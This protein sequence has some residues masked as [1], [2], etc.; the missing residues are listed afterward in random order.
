MDR[1]KKKMKFQAW[2]GL[3][4]GLCF[5]CLFS[6]IKIRSVLHQWPKSLVLKVM[7]SGFDL[8]QNPSFEVVT[9]SNALKNV[10]P[11]ANIVSAQCNL[12]HPED[13][14]LGLG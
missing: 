14:V 12:E 4:R 9:S 1:I 3:Q 10:G 5:S 2:S 6:S 11:G 7:T 8:F 13:K